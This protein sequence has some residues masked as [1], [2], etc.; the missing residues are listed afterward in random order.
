M[1]G[2]TYGALIIVML[3]IFGLG[4]FL[5]FLEISLVVVPIVAPIL[6]A[7]PLAD[8][9]AMSPV[10]LGVLIAINLQSSFLTPPFGLSLF[11]LRSV[12]DQSLTTAALYRGVVPFIAL[13]LLA[14]AFVMAWPPLATILPQWLY[15]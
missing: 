13:Q 11:Y 9:S 5:D 12:A 15:G 14:L 8:G 1:P 7:M 2:G 10:W 3:V 6:L 4:F